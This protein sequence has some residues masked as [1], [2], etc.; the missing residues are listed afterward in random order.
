MILPTCNRLLFVYVRG[1]E[2][3]YVHCMLYTASRLAHRKDI[4]TWGPYCVCCLFAM[5]VI[6]M[7]D[8]LD[9]LQDTKHMRVSCCALNLQCRELLLNTMATATL[10]HIYTYSCLL[11]NQLVLSD[12]ESYRIE[13]ANVVVITHSKLQNMYFSW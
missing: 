10:V 1:C 12:S 6:Y 2:H 5:R 11:K 9:L 4:C 8:T 13:C 7:Q 3:V